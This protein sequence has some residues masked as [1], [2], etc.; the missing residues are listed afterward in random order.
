MKE[1]E[2]KRKAYVHLPLL[3]YRECRF[4]GARSR[5]GALEEETISKI[6]FARIGEGGD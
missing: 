5:A 4:D 1:L 3:S 2:E 6:C